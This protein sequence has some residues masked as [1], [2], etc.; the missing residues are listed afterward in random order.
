MMNQKKAE[1]NLLAYRKIISKLMGATRTLKEYYKH[2]EDGHFKLN[3]EQIQI[4][5][6][7][8]EREVEV[9]DYV[10]T[11]IELDNIDDL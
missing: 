5:I 2:L 11:L 4:V 6:D 3:P 8:T 7:S 10:L 1:L 9:L